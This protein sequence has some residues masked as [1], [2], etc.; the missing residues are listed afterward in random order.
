MTSRV[1][2]VAPAWCSSWWTAR[3]T[4]GKFGSLGRPALFVP[5]RVAEVANSSGRKKVGR[6]LSDSSASVGFK[7]RLVAV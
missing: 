3:T 1:R 2:N 7:M 6:R 4:C 5:V